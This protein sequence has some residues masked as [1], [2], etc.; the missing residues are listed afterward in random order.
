[1]PLSDLTILVIHYRT[2]DLLKGCLAELRAHASGARVVVV[3]SGP[4]G[5]R[6]RLS[7]ETLEVPNHSFAH[8][9]NCG[10][11]LTHTP[12]V[13]HMNA[14]VF[15]GAETFPDLLAAAGRPGVGLVGPRVRT[16]AGRF[17]NQGLPYRRHYARLQRSQRNS[18]SV[19]WLSGCLQLLRTE[20]VAQIGG[21]DASLRFY[22]ED[23]EWCLRLR[24]AGWACELVRTDVLHLGGASTPKDP[25]FIVEGYR[26]GYKLSQRYHGALY[27]RLHRTVVRVQSAWNA[28]FAKDA[29]QRQAA[30]QVLEMFRAGRFDES[31]FGETLSDTNL[32]LLPK[33]VEC[34][35]INLD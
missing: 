35:R 7:V 33:N 2:P 20:A 19:P 34:L 10:L 21:M 29:T 8:A 32:A 27:Q 25:R 26:G 4:P 5:E 24:R 30:T 16:R 22:N 3:D 11:K 1:M 13:A 28:R 23:M 17:Q 14:D 31:P 15:V 12:F 9:V 18:A 6:P